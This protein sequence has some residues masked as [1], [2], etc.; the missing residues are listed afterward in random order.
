MALCFHRQMS[1]VLQILQVTGRIKTKF[2]TLSSPIPL[3]YSLTCKAF[4]LLEE[5]LTT[6][7]PLR[8]LT[9]EV[10]LFDVK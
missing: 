6:Q 9:G 7:E 8:V 5:N 1:A 2:P 3:S 4:E 10:W